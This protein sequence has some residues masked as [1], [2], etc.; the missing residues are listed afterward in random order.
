MSMDEQ[1]EDKLEMPALWW[2]S[3]VLAFVLYGLIKLILFNY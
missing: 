2:S 3:P 1:V